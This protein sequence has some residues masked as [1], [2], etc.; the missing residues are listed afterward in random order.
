MPPERSEKPGPESLEARLRR[1]PP[2]PVPA[3]LESKLRAAIPTP[4]SFPGHKIRASANGVASAPRVLP[5]LTQPGSAG[6]WR[7]ARWAGGVSALAAACL[8]IVLAWPKSDGQKSKPDPQ[9]NHLA[10]A[11]S[12]DPVS[13]QSPQDTPWLQARRA[14]DDLKLAPFTWPIEETRPMTVANSIPSDL[15]D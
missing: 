6:R 15:L 2:P 13:S 14:P 1:L 12:T 10:A 4:V 3:D 7:W 5:A 8:L 9:K 11:G